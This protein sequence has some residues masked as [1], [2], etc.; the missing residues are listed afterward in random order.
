MNGSPTQKTDKQRKRPSGRSSRTN[1]SPQ[2]SRRNFL[3][4]GIGAL[5]ALAVLEV[6]GAS[7]LFMQPR[8]VSGE[9]GGTVTAGSVESFPPGSVTEFPDGRFF[10]IRAEDGGFLA[11][12]HRCTHLGCTVSWE[13]EQNRFFCPCHASHFDFYGDVAA[14]PAPRALDTFA[15]SIAEGEIIVDTSQVQTRDAFIAQQLV[16]A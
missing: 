10:L 14:P 8:T 9:F 13:A 11:V 16:Y 12:Y 3:K 1:N 6:G 5:S 15:L 2:L 4:M 7:L